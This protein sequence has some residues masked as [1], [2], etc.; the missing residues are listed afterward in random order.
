[1]TPIE[2]ELWVDRGRRLS[3]STSQRSVP[4]WCTASARAMTSSPNWS[5]LMRRSGSRL[6]DRARRPVPR[7]VGGATGRVLLVV[8]DPEWLFAQAVAAGAEGKSP[9]QDEHDWRVG[10]S[11]IRSVTC[12]RSANR[13]SPGRHRTRRGSSRSAPDTAEI[14]GQ[15]RR[16]EFRIVSHE[17]PRLTECVVGRLCGR[18]AA[19]L[20]STG[21][22]G[23]RIA[24]RGAVGSRSRGNAGELRLGREGQVLVEGVS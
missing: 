23:R 16:S 1:M 18:L 24:A 5:S 11:S 20:P 21:G 13:S 14:I 15:A 19:L 6:L 17:V 3:R 4:G 10:G 2:P 22:G 9:V 8:D 12:G 7:A